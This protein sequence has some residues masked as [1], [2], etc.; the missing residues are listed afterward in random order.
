MNRIPV[1]AFAIVV[2]CA[3][4]S[5]VTGTRSDGVTITCQV[6]EFYYDCGPDAPPPAGTGGDSIVTPPD[7]GSDTG[8]GDG[9]GMGSDCGENPE[10]LGG[11]SDGSDGSGGGSDCEPWPNGP[12]TVLWPPNHKLHTY[13]LADCAGITMCPNGQQSALDGTVT[14][15]TVDEDIDVGQGGDGHTTDYDA[16]ILDATHFDL[17]SE[18]QGGGDGRVYT[19]YYTDSAGN[20]GSCQFLVPHNRGPFEGAVD[21]GTVVTV[22]P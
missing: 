2:G 4:D 8:S 10:C 14:Q 13:S 12:A 11:G 6:G 22:L 16:K 18:R 21:S 15:I 1:L 20:A 7:T 3:G 17:R 19:V 9:S 5:V